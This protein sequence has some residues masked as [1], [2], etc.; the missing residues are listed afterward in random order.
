MIDGYWR[1]LARTPHDTIGG[2]PWSWFNYDPFNQ[3]VGIYNPIF[4]ISVWS[5]FP[6]EV[7]RLD[8]PFR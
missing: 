5:Q 6:S 7:D 3:H 8:V 1:L 2:I 4:R